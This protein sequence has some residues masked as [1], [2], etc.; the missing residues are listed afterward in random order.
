MT[1]K[2]VT[3]PTHKCISM[4]TVHKSGYDT[5]LVCWQCIPNDEA[6]TITDKPKIQGQTYSGPPLEA[7][8]RA[9]QNRWM[10]I[11]HAFQQRRGGGLQQTI[12]ITTVP[13]VHTAVEDVHTMWLTK[14][15]AK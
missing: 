9:G 8:H 15:L 11:V 4:L 3:A 10:C 13:T 7:H 5:A 1:C 14:P 2:K 6:W 12:N